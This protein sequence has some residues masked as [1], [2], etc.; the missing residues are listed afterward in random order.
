MSRRSESNLISI[1]DADKLIAWDFDSTGVDLRAA[2]VDI[3]RLAV[4][5]SC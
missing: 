2:V 4:H 3:P 1:K 5:F